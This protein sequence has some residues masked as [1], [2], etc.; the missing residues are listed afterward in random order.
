MRFGFG[1]SPFEEFF[2]EAP[3]P[4]VRYILYGGKLIQCP[5]GIYR[6]FQEHSKFL[7]EHNPGEESES[8]D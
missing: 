7:I 1:P 3:R 2:H 4:R 5:D 6:P 8:M